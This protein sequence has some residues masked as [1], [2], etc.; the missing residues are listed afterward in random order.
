VHRRGG[1]GPEPD[2]EVL[3]G[4]DG[5]GHAVVAPIHRVAAD[6]GARV[7]GVGGVDALDPHVRSGAQGLDIDLD[8]Q[9]L[10]LPLER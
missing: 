2:Q 1:V 5:A 6:P 3:A 4:Q 9:A 7:V 10:R 8:V